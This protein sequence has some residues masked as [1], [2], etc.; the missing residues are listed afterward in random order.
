V[1]EHPWVRRSGRRDRPG[2]HRARVYR[3]ANQLEGDPE[4]APE[5]HPRPPILPPIPWIPPA[6][7]KLKERENNPGSGV[8]NLWGVSEDCNSNNALI[9]EPERRTYWA[10]AAY[11]ARV[12]FGTVRDSGHASICMQNEAWVRT[13]MARG[14]RFLD[15]GIDIGRLGSRSPYYGLEKDVLREASYPTEPRPWPPSPPYT[16]EPRPSCPR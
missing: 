6:N 10:A 14:S 12:W 1:F 3:T 16:P 13:E 7:I 4:E 2:H 11:R 5:T 8:L 9:G 15:I